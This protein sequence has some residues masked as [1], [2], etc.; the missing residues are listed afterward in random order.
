MTSINDVIQSTL[1]VSNLN[2]AHHVS[3][4]SV[5]CDNNEI[6]IDWREMHV[7]SLNFGPDPGFYLTMLLSAAWFNS[8][9][10]MAGVGKL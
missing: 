6:A 9:V 10:S 4:I 1:K 2:P 8:L 7:K 3:I 5:S